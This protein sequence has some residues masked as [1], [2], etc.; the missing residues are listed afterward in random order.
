MVTNRSFL[1]GTFSSRSVILGLSVVTITYILVNIAFLLVLMPEEVKSSE[2][3]K[4][5][6]PFSKSQTTLLA[7]AGPHICFCTLLVT[8]GNPILSPHLSLPLWISSWQRIHRRQI[9]FRRLSG[10]S[11]PKVGATGGLPTGCLW[12]SHLVPQVPVSAPDGF[13]HPPPCPNPPWPDHRPPA[14]HHPQAWDHP[15]ALRLCQHWLRP[16]RYHQSLCFQIQV[17]SPIKHHPLKQSHERH[18]H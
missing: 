18:D 4:Q 14:G 7:G 10:R 16:P 3:R 12:F 17:T 5:S 6:K 2:V 1:Y 13:K 15:Q 9:C 11:P 8:P